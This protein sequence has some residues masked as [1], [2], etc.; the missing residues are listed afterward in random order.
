MILNHDA[1]AFCQEI[2][3]RD[4]NLE[5]TNL[6]VTKDVTSDQAATANLYSEW[7]ETK[8]GEIKRLTRYL[9]ST[10]KEKQRRD[11]EAALRLYCSQGKLRNSDD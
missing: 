6:K 7:K 1:D 9:S 5:F 11:E 10:L 2:Y 3:I 8:S 4:L